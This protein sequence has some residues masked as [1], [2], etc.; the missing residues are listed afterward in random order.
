MVS[1]AETGKSDGNA[2]GAGQ[3]QGPIGRVDMLGGMKD[4]PV[5]NRFDVLTSH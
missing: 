2:D 5:R 3:I 1:A 4:T